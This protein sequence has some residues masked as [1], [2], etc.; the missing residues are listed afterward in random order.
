M[1]V[2]ARYI[3]KLTAITGMFSSVL[4]FPIYQSIV[5]QKLFACTANEISYKIEKIISGPES[6][7]GQP[8]MRIRFGSA[9]TLAAI[10]RAHV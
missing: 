10:E 8:K 9:E 6:G 1:I 7:R 5:L 2:H 4:M 3:M